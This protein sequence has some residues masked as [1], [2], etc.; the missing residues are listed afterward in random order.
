MSADF[1]NMGGYATYVWGSYAAGLAVLA[2][3]LVV[4]RLTRSA[5]LGKLRAGAVE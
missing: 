4:P 1:W 2:W 3:N 5:L